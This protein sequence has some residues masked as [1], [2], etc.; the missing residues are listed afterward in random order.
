MKPILES[1]DNLVDNSDQ[2]LTELS[3]LKSISGRD[4][5]KRLK[6]NAKDT[7]KVS[8]KLG[9]YLSLSLTLL[10]SFTGSTAALA[11]IIGMPVTAIGALITLSIYSSLFLVMLLT[12]T[13]SKK[14]VLMIYRF[15]KNMHDIAKVLDNKKLISLEDLQRQ[16]KANLNNYNEK[17]CNKFKLDYDSIDEKIEKAKKIEAFNNFKECSYNGYLTILLKNLDVIIKAYKIYLIKFEDYTK[18][19]INDVTTFS[20]LFSLPIVNQ[21]LRNSGLD[22]ISRFDLILRS[23]YKINVNKRK[24]WQRNLNKLVKTN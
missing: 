5:I 22:I 24:H 3:I 16:T 21:N 17:H 1:V 7:Y 8:S 14:D 9:M 19:E 4:F 6:S 20:G 12:N 11:L 23:F 13:M 2:Y 15:D 10:M 18:A